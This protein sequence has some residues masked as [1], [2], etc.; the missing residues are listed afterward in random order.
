MD[1]VRHEEIFSLMQYRKV[2]ADIRPSMIEVRRRL[3]VFV[4]PY[5]SL[6]FENHST[7]LHQIQEMVWAEAITDLARVREEIETYNALIPNASELV[8]TMFIEI[9]DLDEL[10]NTIPN[11]I[12]IENAVEIHLGGHSIITGIGEEDRSSEVRTSTVHYVKFLFEEED[13]IKFQD[14]NLSAE[15]V[16]NHPYYNGRASIPDE[17]R[18]ILSSELTT[19]NCPTP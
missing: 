18:A 16:V 11:L 9:A 17:T 4:G 10:R 6:A 5:V 8:A 2:R 15:I 19:G 1:K 14:L 12:A 7:I 3:R 13:L